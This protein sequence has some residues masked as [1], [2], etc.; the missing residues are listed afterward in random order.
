MVRHRANGPD[1]EPRRLSP[2]AQ[3][4]PSDESI[5]A[6]MAGPPAIVGGANHH[7]EGD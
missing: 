2:L 6:E 7:N 3:E 5:R 4:H 1:P